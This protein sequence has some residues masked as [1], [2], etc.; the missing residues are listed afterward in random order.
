MIKS[1]SRHLIKT[2]HST[3]I[4]L[5]C[6]L[7]PKNFLVTAGENFSL[8]FKSKINL[9][10]LRGGAS[11]STL[12][13]NA[14][15]LLP[16]IKDIS[17]KTMKELT[18]DS[19]IRIIFSD[20]DGTLAHYPED[21]QDDDTN[22]DYVKFPVSSTGMRGVISKSTL[23]L[24]QKLKETQTLSTNGDPDNIKL[25]LVSG[26]RTTTLM[27]RLPFLPLADAYCTENGGRIFYPHPI[28]F[29][30]IESE[31]YEKKG[32][33][34]SPPLS[35]DQVIYRLQEDTE[36]REIMS[37]IEAAGSGGYH[38]TSPA[39]TIPVESRKGVL[40]EFAADLMRDGWVIDHR[41][42]ATAFRIHLHK[43]V[44]PKLDEARL[45][46]AAPPGLTITSNLA[47]FDVY[48]SCSG[49]RNV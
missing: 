46:Q 9:Y 37:R 40:W 43:Q 19:P 17:S 22:L 7:I 38:K 42:Y 26:M 45:R 13:A 48:P 44:V 47:S 1:S 18:S 3:Y 28:P 39:L 10:S 29:E 36:W 12:T 41:G 4:L 27:K 21:L 30:E 5:S 11:S 23:E 49:K 31:S 6:L 2:K 24:C 34:F 16:D 33:E 35:D 8:P 32:G 25:V 20:V 14:S 15:A